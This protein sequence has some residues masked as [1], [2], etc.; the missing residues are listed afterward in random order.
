[1]NTSSR[2]Q[3]RLG[4]TIIALAVTAGCLFG[5]ATAASAAGLRADEAA[6]PG[7]TAPGSPGL[8]APPSV[9]RLGGVDRYAVSAAVS[10]DTFAPMVSV[11]YIASGAVY[12]DAL[13]ASAAAGAHGGGVLLVEKN[14]IPA[15]IG[16]E[17]ARLRPQRIIV[18]GGTDTISDGVER[19]LQPYS[20]MV[21][22]I[23]GADR[24]AVS[25][26]VSEQAFGPA[27]PVAYIASGTAFPDALSGSAA[28]GRLGGPVLL[29]QKTSVP[30]AVAAEL[31]RLSPAKVVVLGGVNTIAESVVNEL[32][33]T[34]PTVRVAGA[35]R[36][37]VSAAVSASAFP[38]GAETVYVASGADYPDALSGGAAAIA[39][40]APVLLVTA[41]AVPAAVDA[42]LE[43][44]N[45]HRIVVLGGKYSVSDTVLTSLRHYLTP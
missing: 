13:S 36:F 23:A 16:R 38:L 29:V 2:A 30:G 41:D 34:A 37:A 26:A 31:A 15:A 28:A 39:N 21:T 18:L 45:P 1:M 4:S 19:D 44:L 3:R 24:F 11:V 20:P 12:S 43:R 9:D 22:R 25:A 14:S 27:R 17:L 40:A 10:A 8:L 6:P 7:S 42:E 32:K 35:D 33:G 5:G